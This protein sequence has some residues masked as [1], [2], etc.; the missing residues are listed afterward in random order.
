M[1]LS[2]VVNLLAFVFGFFKVGEWRRRG[3]R[4]ER[5]VVVMFLGV[6]ERRTRRRRRMLGDRQRRK[7]AR[8]PPHES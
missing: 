6:G 3:A 5:N 7:G 2:F 8:A 4:R 1:S